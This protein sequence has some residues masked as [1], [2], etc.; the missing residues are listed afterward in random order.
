MISKQPDIFPKLYNNPWTRLWWLQTCIDPQE[1]GV[2]MSPLSGIEAFARK[3]RKGYS[4]EHLFSFV[5]VV[6]IHWVACNIDPKNFSVNFLDLLVSGCKNF[7]WWTPFCN[8]CKIWFNIRCE[9]FEVWQWCLVI[10]LGS[11]NEEM[12]EIWECRM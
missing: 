7:V 8:F 2:S 12:S 6:K 1:N 5:Y 4:S 11:I 10:S 9:N 3:C